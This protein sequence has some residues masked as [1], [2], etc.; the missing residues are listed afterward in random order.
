MKT[1]IPFIYDE[2]KVLLN[3]HMENIEE[4][5][6]QTSNY[7]CEDLHVRNNRPNEYPKQCNS[8]KDNTILRYIKNSV[9]YFTGHNIP[10]EK[11]SKKIKEIALKVPSRLY[12]KFLD[13]IWEYL[14]EDMRHILRGHSFYDH[15]ELLNILKYN[16]MNNDPIN[17]IKK[18]LENQE[19]QTAFLISC[20]GQL[21]TV[22]QKQ[23]VQIQEQS[24]YECEGEQVRQQEEIKT[25]EIQKTLKHG[26]ISKW[27][28]NIHH[29][30]QEFNC[31]KVMT[32]KA[33]AITAA[34]EKSI[35]TSTVE[36]TFLAKCHRL[37][38]KQN[39]R[40]S[41]VTCQETKTII[42]THEEVTKALITETDTSISISLS[43]EESRI[44]QN[45]NTRI[46][47]KIHKYQENTAMPE[48][49]SPVINNQVLKTNVYILQVNGQFVQEISHCY[50]LRNFKYKRKHD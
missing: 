46:P 47:R 25:N 32:Q 36:P 1:G 2:S 30:C 50:V 21:L 4:R 20:V 45:N 44:M 9:P 31:N 13:I 43:N 24:A 3:K 18:G 26:E 16:L 39:Y 14:H 37:N 19:L 15:L 8:R 6:Q 17:K 7:L 41:N 49:K 27:G 40:K 38:E 29:I 12:E 22:M 5:A 33:S 10:F 34:I 11:Y 42:R 35:A 23:N 28:M 48:P